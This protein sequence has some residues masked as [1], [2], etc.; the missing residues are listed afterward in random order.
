MKKARIDEGM[1]KNINIT[2]EKETTFLIL[3]S[4]TKSWKAYIFPVTYKERTER[5]SRIIRNQK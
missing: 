2:K 4:I 5:F 1:E 3:T